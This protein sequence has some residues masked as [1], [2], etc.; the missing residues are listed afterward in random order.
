MLSIRLKELRKR[1]NITQMQFAKIFDISS[2]TIAMWETGKRQPDHKTLLKIANYFNVSV[3]YLLGKETKK[4]I[5]LNISEMS[6]IVTFD[7]FKQI[8]IIGTI[9]C[10]EPILAEEN[11]EGYTHIEAVIH[12]DFGLKCRGDSMSP[13]FLDGD[14]VLIRQQPVV[15]NGQ[16][17][18]VIIDNEA[19][20]KRVYVDS[21]KIVLNPENLSYAPMVYTGEQMNSV[22]II[23]LA[24]G[25]TRLF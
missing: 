7:R 16:I 5:P 2:G 18:A 6:N 11:I 12:A 14:I 10:G 25:Y 3:D 8:P 13:K 1:E 22:R 15:D 24:V 23:G 19:T 9:A 17:A 4:D 21:D 20:L